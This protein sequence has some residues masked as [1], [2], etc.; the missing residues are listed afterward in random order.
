MKKKLTRVIEECIDCDYFCGKWEHWCEHPSFREEGKP[1]P[2]KSII[3][4][5]IM[6]DFPE[7][8]PLENI[9]GEK[10]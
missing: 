3:D 2:M 4:T 5:D 9:D 8:C 6:N 1:D 10:N 7:W